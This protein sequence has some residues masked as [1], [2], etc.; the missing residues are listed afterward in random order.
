MSIVESLE[1]VTQVD[2]DLFLIEIEGIEVLFSLPPSKKVEQYSS[3]AGLLANNETLR[4]VFYEY[5][6]TT[7]VEDKFLTKHGDDIPAGIPTTIAQ[8]I[9]Y[10][11]GADENAIEYTNNLLDLY[12]SNSN[13]VITRI[14]TTICKT[15]GG[16][17]FSDLDKLNYQELIRIFTQAEQVLIDLGII[18]KENILRIQ[19]PKEVQQEGFSIEK[20]IQEDA[21]AYD[22]FDKEKP[23]QKIYNDPAYKAK[24]QQLEE[25]Y[26]RLKMGG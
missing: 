24:M 8:L 13:S 1:A 14:K 11:S 17:K 5:I 18:E 7:Y 9:L 26:K 20:T 4:N 16:Y 25:K 23:N 2:S 12:R 3:L 15:F 22:K 10:M 19:K 21:A 6:F